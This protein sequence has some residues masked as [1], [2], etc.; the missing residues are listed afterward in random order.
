MRITAKKGRFRA[1]VIAGTR[2]VLVALDCDESSRHGLMGFA[3]R[4]ET[5]GV[6]DDKPKWLRS[7]KVFKSLVPNPEEALNPADPTKQVRFSTWEHPIQS[8]LWG[9]YT[10]T[11]DTL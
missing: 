9:D 10:A 11:P 5:V 1:K 4:R 6:K 2:A 3:F 8:F 7:Q